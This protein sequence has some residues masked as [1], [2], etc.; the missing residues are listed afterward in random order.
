M[1]RAAVLFCFPRRF[2]NHPRM[3]LGDLAQRIGCA[4]E[5]DPT[6]E[7]S[8]PATIDDAGPGQVTFVANPRYQSRLKSLR[9]SAVILAPG[10]EAPGVAILR[11]EQP[12]AAFVRLLELFH[13]P[14][15]RDPGI[16]PTASVS[17]GAR[18][19]AGAAIG[20][21]AVIGDAVTIGADARIDAHVVIYPRVTIGDRFTAHAHAVVREGVTIGNEVTLQSGAVIGGDGF[22]YLPDEQGRVRPIPQT[23]T[24]VLEDGVDIGANTTI[25]RA[26]VGATR[27]RRGA[28]IDNLVQVGHGCEVGESAMLA[29]QVG[30]AGSTQVGAG[31][32]L[33]GQVGAAG[34]LVIG[35]GARVGAKS[36]V[37]ND[38][39]PGATVASGI[40]AF[41]IRV[42]RR[43]I[44]ALRALPDMVQRLRHVEKRLGLRGGEKD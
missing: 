25:D 26:A 7:I 14:L 24:V 8:G 33:G 16:H 43:V 42:Y 1:K 29:A 11:T 17:P 2:D 5:G 15:R 31:A 44:A 22:G 21:Y 38:V 13:E 27:I 19:G 28:K 23:G 39:P 35:A 10:G 32:Q 34:H 3:K 6:I 20:P 18:I 12:Y 36:G 41:E 9:A 4:L 30:L 37:P 40:P